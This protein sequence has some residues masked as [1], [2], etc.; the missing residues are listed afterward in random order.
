MEIGKSCYYYN[1]NYKLCIIRNCTLEL[2]LYIEQRPYNCWC[3]F[4]LF[5]CCGFQNFHNLVWI[6]KIRSLK[7]SF[8]VVACSLV[9]FHLLSKNRNWYFWLVF[10]FQKITTLLLPHRHCRCMVSR[11][12][13]QHATRS[14]W[15]QQD[16]KLQDSPPN[17]VQPLVF[18]HEIRFPSW[19][20]H[21]VCILPLR[22]CIEKWRRGPSLPFRW[23]IFGV[24]G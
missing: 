18:Q 10:C 12:G 21:S 4:N 7:S 6:L 22:R 1:M 20:E 5:I 16:R 11:M 15:F 13:R 2:L 24:Q 9:F 23:P 17:A 14:W 8:D 3:S 19:G